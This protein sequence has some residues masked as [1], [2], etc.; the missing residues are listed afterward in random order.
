MNRFLRSTGIVLIC[1]L[2]TCCDCFADAVW[3]AQEH[4]QLAIVYSHG[5]ESDA[6]ERQK[7]KKVWGYDASGKES[8]IKLDELPG[9]VVIQPGNSI[10]V[11]INF[12]NGYW[13][14]KP[15]KTWVNF[16]RTNVDGALDSGHY[17]KTS[18]NILAGH[19]RLGRPLGLWLEIIPVEDPYSLK[20]GDDL[21]I[22]VVRN[23]KPAA[24][25]PVVR[26]YVNMVDEITGTTD[27]NGRTTIRIRNEGLNVIAVTDTVKTPGDPLAVKQETISS[28][29]F[30]LPHLPD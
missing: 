26:D 24:G 9:H 10:V 6:Y 21:H 16:P 13:S 8:A 23:G 22:Q 18:V 3:I 29:S 17:L 27:S 25:L 14:Q 2:C 1:L 4:G 30:T 7:I 5:A 28:L 20:A 11:L 19:A 12:D 15:D